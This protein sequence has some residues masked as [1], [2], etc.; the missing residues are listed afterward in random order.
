MSLLMIPV[1][2]LRWTAVSNRQ[3]V[4]YLGCTIFINWL[5][6][7]LWLNLGS[8]WNVSRSSRWILEDTMAAWSHPVAFVF[9]G[10]TWTTEQT[11]ASNST[12]GLANPIRQQHD[13][14]GA[15]YKNHALVFTG[16]WH[17]IWFDGLA[18]CAELLI[19]WPTRVEHWGLNWPDW[20]REMKN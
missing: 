19:D 17:P 8:K 2:I 7:W 5:Q 14:I 12:A 20:L 10:W 13:Q 1:V 18:C 16:S 6:C 11:W 3:S 9:L 4:L 15:R